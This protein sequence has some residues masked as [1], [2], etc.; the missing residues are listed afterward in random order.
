VSE[1]IAKR[2]FVSGIVQGVG[3]RFFAQR[4]AAKLGVRG[5]VTNLFDGRVE[6][7]A[8][9]THETLDAMRKELSRGP[10]FAKVDEVAETDAELLAEFNSSFSIEHEE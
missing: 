6:V 9:G 3:Y 8:I 4:V 10:S 5:Y 2:F 1:L 7:Y